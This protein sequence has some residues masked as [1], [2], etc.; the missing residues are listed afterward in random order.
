MR[1]IAEHSEALRARRISSAELVDQALARIAAAQP[2][3]NAFVSV[4]AQN[5]LGTP[6]RANWS[7]TASYSGGDWAN[8]QNWRLVD[9]RVQER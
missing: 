9:L 3:L 2:R 5:N 7:C 4:D 6:I 8:P 1:T